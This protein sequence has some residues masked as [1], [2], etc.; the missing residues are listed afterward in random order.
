MAGF[1]LEKLAT[2]HLPN[3]FAVAD[4]D[5]AADSHNTWPPLNL[6]PFK[7]III[8]IHRLSFDGNRPAIVRVVYNKVGVAAGLYCALA[9]EQSKQLR[10]LRTGSIH[11]AMQIEASAFH[12]VSVEHIDAIFERRNSIRN[13]SEI[14]F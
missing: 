1:A 4:G 5:L 6:C 3:E 2:T 13:F 10:G 9:G 12:S 8:H 7:G 14:L 11:E